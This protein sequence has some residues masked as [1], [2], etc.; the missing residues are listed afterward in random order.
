MFLKLNKVGLLIKQQQQQYLLPMINLS[1]QA[2][3]IILENL[4]PLS[5]SY[6]N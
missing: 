1:L 3:I 6:E 4:Y 2:K 5:R